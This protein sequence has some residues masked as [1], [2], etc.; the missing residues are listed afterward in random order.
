MAMPQTPTIWRIKFCENKLKNP[1]TPGS[2]PIVRPYCNQSLSRLTT[3]AQSE[4]VANLTYFSVY[5]MLIRVTP[6]IRWLMYIRA[7]ALV[8]KR[9]Q[10][11]QILI[12]T[13]TSV[14]RLGGSFNVFGY[15]KQI[16]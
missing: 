4:H 16:F 13:Q 9:R 11:G 15:L 10:I 2:E 1:N 8:G 6:V 7:Y 14:T 5:S 3:L 12:S